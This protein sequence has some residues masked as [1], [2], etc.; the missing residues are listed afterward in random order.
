MCDELYKNF[1][2]NFKFFGT[3]KEPIP[4]MKIMGAENLHNEKPYFIN[5]NDSSEAAALADAWAM[6]ADVA[7]VGCSNCYRFIDVRFK[8]GDKLTFKLRERIFK[9][10]YFDENNHK[11]QKKIAEIVKY[12]D[13]NLFFLAAGTFAPYDLASVGIDE[14][15]IIKWGYFPN[16]STKAYIALKRSYDNPIKL[17]WVG[18]FV[19][20]KHPLNAIIATKFLLEKGYNLTLSLIGYGEQ[21]DLLKKYVADNKLME[22]VL[23]LG[24]MNEHQI[25]QQLQQSHIFLMTS[26]YE[27]GWGVVVNEA[28]SEGCIPIVSYATGASQMLIDKNNYGQLFFHNN[29]DDLVEKT[30][31]V[32]KNKNSLSNYSENAYNLISN[33][34]N[35]ENAVE[36]LIKIINSLEKGLPLPTYNSG[37]C[38]KITLYKDAENISNFLNR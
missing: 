27:E 2:Q 1:G 18:R 8:A 15:K 22:N 25:R 26:D 10:G 19:P 14:K 12:K 30:E 38:G 11:Q 31:A 28:M 3:D 21:E 13:N 29:I 16:T 36:R 35:A 23:F 6:N 33:E 9:S 17:I 5:I 4:A 37:P 7:I 32:I 20:E 24:A 34:W